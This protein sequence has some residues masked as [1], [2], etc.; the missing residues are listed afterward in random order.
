MAGDVDKHNTTA[1]KVGRTLDTRYSAEK[2]IN[3]A[4]NLLGSNASH[5]GIDL[6]PCW[7]FIINTTPIPDVKQI[8]VDF[9]SF[10][11]F[12]LSSRFFISSCK[13]DFKNHI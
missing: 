6:R 9:I 1:R 8:L 12:C 11:I 5:L 13:S 10:F 7:S 2:L 3:T 4:R